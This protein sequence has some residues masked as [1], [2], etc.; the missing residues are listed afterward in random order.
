ME[1]RRVSD[2]RCVMIVLRLLI[3]VP[4]FL[5]PVSVSLNKYLMSPPGV[6]SDEDEEDLPPPKSWDS[7]EVS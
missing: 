1:H 3:T 5:I 7:F 4:S 2:L 6:D